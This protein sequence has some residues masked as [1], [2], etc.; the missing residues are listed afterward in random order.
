MMLLF[1]TGS[2]HNNA[3]PVSGDELPGGRAVLLSSPDLHVYTVEI[4]PVNGGR[5]DAEISA[6]LKSRYP[7][8]LDAAAVC[9]TLGRVR[10]DKE[11]PYRRAT[12]FLM[13]KETLTAY[14]ET[15]KLLVPS[16]AVLE[17]AFRGME[18]RETRGKPVLVVFI[19]KTCMEAAC[20]E[21]R[22]LKEYICARIKSGENADEVPAFSL[23]RTLCGDSQSDGMAVLLI[24]R[25]T[26]KADKDPGTE[27]LLEMFPKSKI[28]SFDK[29][30]G[31][32]N[33]KK[34]S[35]FGKAAKKPIRFLAALLLPAACFFLLSA[36]RSFGVSA[37]NEL[38]I[39]EVQ[40]AEYLRNK[41]ETERLLNEI[42]EQKSLIEMNAVRTGG[43]IEVYAVIGEIHSRLAGAWVRSLAVDGDR[44]T[45]E[46][47]GADSI[48]VLRGLE[49]AGCFY[50][51]AL[52]QA[53]PS[54]SRGEQFTIS[55]R[56][57]HGKE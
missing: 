17:A 36:F 21:D 27:K 50:N 41:E 13:D 29:T 4:P 42:A 30:L 9:Y 18:R 52:H 3:N 31:K 22:E 16:L 20:F 57:Y 7:G 1:N 12:V 23:L 49:Q 14:R 34:A 56:I 24:F 15:G 51:L 2:F 6:R 53:L 28:I 39:L 54:E 33:T 32:L 37:G 55:G 19:N 48:V 40:K 43:G 11:Q 38:K 35:V 25:E 10:R 44:F 46:A 45:L 26:N 8:N 5:R 47:E